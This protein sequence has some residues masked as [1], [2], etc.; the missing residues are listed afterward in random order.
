MCEGVFFKPK[1]YIGNIIRYKVLLEYS[2]Y[3][4]KSMLY[5]F[6]IFY[7]LLWICLWN[8]FYMIVG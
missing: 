5:N 4:F 3:F 6:I 8:G 1:I 2:G 7:I